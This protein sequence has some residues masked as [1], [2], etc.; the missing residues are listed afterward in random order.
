MKILVAGASGFIGTHIC[1]AL[2]QR[3]HQVTGLGR[4]PERN[5]I[6]HERYRFVAADTTLPGQWQQCLSEVEAVIN[7]AGRTIF[8]RWSEAVKTE[9][10]QSRILT[11]RH[12]AQGLAPA[13]TTTFISAS[14]VGFYG[15]RGDDVLT[16]DE[17]AGEDF[18]A[19]LS[20]DWEG[21]ALAAAEKGVRVV[22]MRLGV[23]LGE[24]G[25]ALAQMI[26]A[27]KYFVGG[28][29]GS[30]H[31]WFPWI[32]LDDLTAAV[33]F[34]L[35]GRS[36]SGPVNLCAPNPVQN[37]KLASA[38]GQA[39]KRPAFMPAPAFMVRMVLGEFAQVL[40][41]SQRA[42][43]Q[44]LRQHQFSFRYPDIQAALGA[45]VHAGAP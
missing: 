27:F 20:V 2:L 14:G 10:R 45:A 42:V 5:R 12:V 19:R 30:G 37:R 15:N 39:L 3:N 13:K 41:A 11:T 18:L 8:G 7:L 23:V 29:I 35:E 25:G 1:R 21:E 26:P 44:K 16:E 28:P 22:L 4:S 31:Q 36:I 9:I 34:L 33:N 24:G 38:L 17:P 32:H 6:S 40:L 43:P